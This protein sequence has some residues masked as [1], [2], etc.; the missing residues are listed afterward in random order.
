MK[1]TFPPESKPLDG[2]TIKR[3]IHRGG[4]GEVYYA[5]SNAG[6]EV[7]LKLLQQNLEIELRGVTQ[8]MNLKHPNLV[9]IF[10]IRQDRDGDHWIVMEYVHGRSLDKIIDDFDGPMP[11]DDVERRLSGMV[12]GLGFLHDRGIVHRDLKPANVFEENGVVKIGDVGLAKFI[13][14]SQR[15][16]QTESVGTVYYM[17]PEVARGRYGHEV[18]IYSLGIVLY[19]M[20]TGRVPFDGESTA[21]ILMKHLSDKPD[22]SPIPKRLR[23]VLAASLEKDP[24]KR[25]SSV[26]RLLSDFRKAIA[27][28][29]I[30]TEIP[31]ESFHLEPEPAAM[32]GAVA[33]VASAGGEDKRWNRHA[34]VLDRK[35][36]MRARIEAR[37][38]ARHARRMERQAARQARDEHRKAARTHEAMERKGARNG[39]P[40]AVAAR[41]HRPAKRG[42]GRTSRWGRWLKISAIVVL[43]LAL[44]TPRTLTHLMGGVFRLALLSIPI[45][46]IYLLFFANRKSS[47]TDT[48]SAAPQRAVPVNDLERP[49]VPQ[50]AAVTAPRYV[51]HVYRHA[52]TPSTPRDVSLRTRATELTGSLSFAVLAT[53]ILTAAAVI[54]LPVFQSPARIALFATGTLV[55][56]WAVLMTAKMYEGTRV[57]GGHRRFMQF[58]AGGVV[59]AVVYGLHQFLLVQFDR[60]DFSTHTTGLVDTV[61]SLD[62]ARSFQPTLTGYVVF[63][64]ALF[65]IRHWWRHADSLRRKRLAIGSV[66]LTTMVGL[67]LSLVLTFP[68]M[69]GVTW[70]AAISCVVHLSAAWATPEE[71]RLMTEAADVSQ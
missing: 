43:V 37:K 26:Q 52:L 13:T 12:Q 20:L 31:E 17:A 48:G 7:A 33:G 18:D 21:E 39:R 6:K 51:R 40:E 35:S 8:C 2:Y 22:L 23:P 30:P 14:Q 25:M 59:G 67:V 1:F 41:A 19:E 46:L 15:S 11:M 24:L 54:L 44:V 71:R 42:D 62:L 34:E 28:V 29:D 4:F 64:A 58:L 69:W 70:A 61:G 3:A 49:V 38:A 65:L 10:D 27:G 57:G 5:I 68:L 32:T 55:A 47:K 9:T 50:Q 36:E 66:L 45:Y 56:S 60:L 63:F 53:A 16:A